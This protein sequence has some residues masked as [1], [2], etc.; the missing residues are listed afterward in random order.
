MIDKAWYFIKL[1]W[2]CFDVLLM[3][4]HLVYYY[5]NHDIA[6]FYVILNISYPR[7]R[8]H[9]QADYFRFSCFS[10]LGI[11]Y[12][13]ILQFKFL[14]WIISKIIENQN[15][16]N[17]MYQYLFYY[18]FTAYND[19]TTRPQLLSCHSHQQLHWSHFILISFRP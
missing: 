3:Y 11:F 16:I 7:E 12:R 17:L 14:F 13:K 4:W 15:R 10:F 6:K 5:V 19:I 9:N 18:W 2:D 8:F 1:L